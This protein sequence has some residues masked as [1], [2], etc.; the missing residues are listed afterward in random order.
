MK[1]LDTRSN[2]ERSDWTETVCDKCNQA[3]LESETRYIVTFRRSPSHIP[4]NVP[5]NEMKQYDEELLICQAC[6][7]DIMSA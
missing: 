5:F 3:I 6:V 1:G 7:D 2:V 4:M